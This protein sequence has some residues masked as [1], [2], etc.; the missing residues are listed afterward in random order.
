MPPSIHQLYNLCS[1]KCSRSVRPHGA[2]GLAAIDSGSTCIAVR[3]H[4]TKR[5]KKEYSGHCQ[6]TQN[7][8]T[9]TRD[10]QRRAIQTKRAMTTMMKKKKIK[11]KLKVTTRVNN[12]RRRT[13]QQIFTYMPNE[14][15]GQVDHTPKIKKPLMARMTM[16]SNTFNI[17]S[18]L[19]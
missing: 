17:F 16:V 3:R 1:Q 13:I 6:K 19:F 14:P 11:N 12:Q 10:A 5:R 9:S 15:Q 7:Q 2:R 4:W 8:G 18:S